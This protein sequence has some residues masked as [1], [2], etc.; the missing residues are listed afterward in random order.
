MSVYHQYIKQ[1]TSQSVVKKQLM[2]RYCR[3]TQIYKDSN[4]I[5]YVDFLYYSIRNH[6]EN[7]MPI[8]ASLAQSISPPNRL[9][10]AVFHSVLLSDAKLFSLARFTRVT[11]LY[12][13][14]T[15]LLRLMCMGYRVV[16]R[17]IISS[18]AIIELHNMF[19][20]S[21]GVTVWLCLMKLTVNMFS[22]CIGLGIFLF[23]LA[24]GW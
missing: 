19:K 1:S 23:K 11:L 17:P 5:V 14:Q 6:C 9:Q 15:T 24:L 21:Q 2:A 18:D 12:D 4:K 7:S 3:P 8:L 13:V 20:T 10:I 22:L 16:L